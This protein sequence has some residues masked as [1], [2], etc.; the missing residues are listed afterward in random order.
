MQIHSN[1]LSSNGI[2]GAGSAAKGDGG[3]S[4]NSSGIIQSS[5]TL[6]GQPAYKLTSAE[7]AILK[8]VE[9][10][11]KAS[12]GELSHTEYRMHKNSN[13]IVVRLVDTATNNVIHEYPSEKILDMLDKFME[14]NGKVIDERR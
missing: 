6:K 1:G 5:V 9:R 7:Q 3:I 14:I 2:T 13:D 4:D 11:N 12:A 10:A 8:A